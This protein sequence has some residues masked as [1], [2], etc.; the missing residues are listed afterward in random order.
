MG[1]L[2]T[3][4]LPNF[5]SVLLQMPLPVLVLLAS[6][7]LMVLVPRVACA[8]LGGACQETGQLLES[9]NSKIHVL[10][11]LVEK[12]GPAQSSV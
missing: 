11:L 10:P 9:V 8:I 2:V 6:A 3:T 5:L 4:A 12:T 1:F 7:Q